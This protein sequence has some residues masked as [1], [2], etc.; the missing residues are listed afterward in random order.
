MVMAQMVRELMQDRQPEYHV[1]VS[2]ED[3][4]QWTRGF[5]F[6]GLRNQRYGQS[7]CNKFDIVDNILYFSSCVAD[8]DAYIRK[9]YVK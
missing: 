2:Q 5:V 6:E 7:F 3:Y 8:A 9:H 1:K 4:K